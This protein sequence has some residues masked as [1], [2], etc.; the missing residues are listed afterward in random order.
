MKK[1]DLSIDWT[2]GIT[3]PATAWTDRISLTYSISL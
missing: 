2:T 3:D 1:S